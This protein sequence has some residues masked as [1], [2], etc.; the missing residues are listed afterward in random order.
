M[1][2]AAYVI[3]QRRL[4]WELLVFEQAGMPEA[5]V[6]IPAGGVRAG[7]TLRQA[8]LREVAEETGLVALELGVPLQTEDKPHPISGQ[9]RTTT[10][11][12][13]EAARQTP[14]AWVHSVLGDGADAAMVFNCRFAALPL[15]YPL[16]DDQDAWLGLIDV[17]FTTLA[18]R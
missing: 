15:R 6:Q 11:F 10:F 12:V 13:V 9:S 16:A 14:H 4:A 8:V 1:R 5:G 18:R 2:V 7:E 17:D 3:R